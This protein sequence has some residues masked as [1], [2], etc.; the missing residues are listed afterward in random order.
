MTYGQRATALLIVFF[1]A[2][3]GAS[4]YL[5]V[6]AS[7]FASDDMKVGKGHS[8]FPPQAPMPSNS[9]KGGH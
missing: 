6:A 9:P 5:V 8:K 2:M 3:L 7:Q 4:G 1:V